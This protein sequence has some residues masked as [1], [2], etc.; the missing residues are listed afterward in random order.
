M[1]WVESS[2]PSDCGKVWG[3]VGYYLRIF[4]SPQTIPQSLGQL[5]STQAITHFQSGLLDYLTIC[6]VPRPLSVFHLGQAVLG[7]VVGAKKRLLKRIDREGLR[8]SRTGKLFNFFLQKDE[9]R[10]KNAD[11]NCSSEIKYANE[12]VASM[13]I[14]FEWTI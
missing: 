14:S 11:L 8:E 1:A 5:L 7:H 12:N 3:D 6:L 2:C 10:W 9:N 13:N 4:A